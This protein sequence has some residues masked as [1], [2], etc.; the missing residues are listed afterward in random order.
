ML[1]N[2]IDPFQMMGQY[3]SE[4]CMSKNA[5]D[6]PY[7][8]EY[9]KLLSS[10]RHFQERK[11]KVN[12]FEERVDLENEM[13]LV[14]EEYKSLFFGDSEGS[15]YKAQIIKMYEKL[16]H[17]YNEVHDILLHRQYEVYYGVSIYWHDILN[18]VGDD[19]LDKI[20]LDLLDSLEQTYF[21]YRNLS[22]FAENEDEISP[23]NLKDLLCFHTAEDQQRFVAIL[24]QILL[25]HKEDHPE[26]IHKVFDGESFDFI[27]T[28]SIRKCF[29]CGHWEAVD[30]FVFDKERNVHICNQWEACEV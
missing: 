29:V 2:R 28:P 10:Y 17:L 26:V 18:V 20:Y 27:Y 8:F 3:C 7:S 13:D 5:F 12:S 15:F 23:A 14:I 16:L 1:E 4:E 21:F 9:I 19:L 22:W 11:Q 25:K 24:K 30:D 6:H